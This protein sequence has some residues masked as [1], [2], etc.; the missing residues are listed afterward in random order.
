MHIPGNLFLSNTNHALSGV[1]PMLSKT[2]P[3][4]PVEYW[5]TREWVDAVQAAFRVRMELFA[6]GLGAPKPDDFLTH[7]VWVAACVEYDA[8][9]VEPIRLRLGAAA[10]VRDAIARKAVETQ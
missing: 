7:A 10:A 6:A 4:V 8:A 9:V 3:N 1:I 5:E 2:V